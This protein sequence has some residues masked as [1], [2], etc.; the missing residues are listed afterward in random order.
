MER[1]QYR[2]RVF[3]ALRRVRECARLEHAG[4]H[5]HRQPAERS[6]GGDGRQRQFCR[7]VD[8]CQPG[9]QRRRHLCP[10]L[11]CQR[12]CPRRRVSRQHHHRQQP[13]AAGGGDGCQ[14]QL[15]RHLDRRRGRRQ[16][17]RRLRT[18]LR[19][20]RLGSGR[21]V[22]GQYDHDQR[23]VVLRHRDERDRQLRHR[24]GEQ[25]DRRQ[26]HLLPALQRGRQHRRGR[27]PRQR[28]DLRHAV[29][30]GRRHRRP[31]QLRRRLGGRAG[32]GRRHQ[33]HLRAPLRRRHRLAGQRIPRQ[34]DDQR[35]A[36]R[37]GDRDE[38]RRRLFGGLEQR[39]SG[40][41][42]AGG[43]RTAV[44]RWRRCLGRGIPRQ[45]DDHRRSA[46]AV[47]RLRR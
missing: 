1:R 11:Q 42:C 3:P 31:G 39:Q 13:G 2:R 22:P 20:R 12:R 45:H 33:R 24:L 27:D 23:A 35:C 19:R 10:A 32:R 28:H 18:A 46:D 9:R 14:R 16:Q 40:H 7:R 21:P 15:R 25:P 37:A 43:L 4:Q 38:R 34:H 47:G 8:E 36:D 6:A 5:H 41:Q 30:R 29:E 44:F 26:R 17:L